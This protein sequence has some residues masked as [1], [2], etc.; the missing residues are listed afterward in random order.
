MRRNQVFFADFSEYLAPELSILSL[1]S[2]T[3]R[4]S[5][6]D[7]RHFILGKVFQL[8][9]VVSTIWHLFQNYRSNRKDCSFA[10]SVIFFT[11][12]I[13]NGFYFL[14]FFFSCHRNYAG[15]LKVAF[16]STST[17]FPSSCLNEC[18]SRDSL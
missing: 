15:L 1:S 4:T 13:D 12:V 11:S 9:E 14:L 10:S 17:F 6:L 7:V 3:S 16:F 8:Q 2:I 18:L 5:L